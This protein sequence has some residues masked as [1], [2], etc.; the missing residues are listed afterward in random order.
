[1]R[2]NMKINGVGEKDNQIIELLR[3]DARMTCS[4]I[5]ERVGLS[6]TAVKNRMTSLEE[7]GI[8]KGYSAVIDPLS[9]SGMTF[10]TTVETTP[11]AYDEIV[12]FLSSDRRVMTLCAVTGEC[13]LHAVCVA[14]SAEEMRSFAQT[15]RNFHQGMKRF[16]AQA[17]YEIMK[18]N[19]I[20]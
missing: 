17:V 5:G 10:I 14:G 6:R 2:E 18:G 11:E 7:R 15:L 3:R 13:L 4:E 20:P 19:L 9:V 12:Q 16:S 1:M 8:I